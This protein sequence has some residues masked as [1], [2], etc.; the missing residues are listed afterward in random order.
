MATFPRIEHISGNEKCAEVK[1]LPSTEK[2][3]VSIE[4]E[5]TD[6]TIGTSHQHVVRN[7][8]I[9]HLQTHTLPSKPDPPVVQRTS[10]ET[11]DIEFRIPEKIR[12][13]K[14]MKY[15]LSYHRTINDTTDL[16]ETEVTL[17]TDTAIIEELE[18]NAE[19]E[20]RFRIDCSFGKSLFSEYV[21]GITLQKRENYHAHV[22]KDLSMPEILKFI[23]EGKCF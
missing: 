6:P 14:G 20:L 17:S 7:G 13:E 12:D 15:I 5:A 1:N 19:Y 16:T 4:A 2:Y 22:A 8:S 18:E 11:I 21:F 10:A 3:Y 23:E 9:S